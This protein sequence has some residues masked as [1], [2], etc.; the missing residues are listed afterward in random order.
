MTEFLHTGLSQL[1]S[2]FP[3][4]CKGENSNRFMGTLE[5]KVPCF[6]PHLQKRAQSN[7]SGAPQ[8]RLPAPPRF[9]HRIP[10]G[11]TFAEKSYLH[12]DLFNHDS[13]Y[14]RRRLRVSAGSFRAI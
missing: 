5:A 4:S 11:A 1:L 2:D 3:M 14:E 8:S 13:I 12:I 7:K 6:K 9:L 10:Y